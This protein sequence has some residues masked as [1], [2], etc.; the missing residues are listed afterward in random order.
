MTLG[1]GIAGC[2]TAELA[3]HPTTRGDSFL[4]DAEARV[5]YSTAGKSVVWNV[6]QRL[7]VSNDG[8]GKLTII[9][10][11]QADVRRL[12]MAVKPK[13]QRG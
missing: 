2:R 12:L 13:T 9:E 3:R 5:P 7:L 1:V 4:Q 8:D 11:R 6:G 10:S